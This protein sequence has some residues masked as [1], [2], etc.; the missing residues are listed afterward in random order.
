M[1]GNLTRI[2][3]NQI[4]DAVGGNTQLGIDASTK[5]QN[6][7]ITS[8]KL[9]NDITYGSNL[10]ITGN[11]AVQ[12]NTTTID[13]T[14][15]T[16]EDPILLLAS[17][18]TGTPAVDIGY[19]GQ[20]GTFDN[21]AFVWDEAN[22]AFVTIYTDST[23]GVDTVNT[24]GYANI[25]TGN[26]NIT[27]N[28]T[29]ANI[30]FSGNVTGDLNVTGN[31]TGNNISAVNG[32]TASTANVTNV[33]NVGSVETVT[34]TATGNVT[35]GNVNTGGNVSATGNVTGGNINTAGNISGA[36]VL[37][38]TLANTQVVFAGTSGE[39]L[40]SNDFVYTSAG[41]NVTGN[42]SAGGNVLGNLLY[43]KEANVASTGTV[44]ISGLPTGDGNPVNGSANLTFTTGNLL[45]VTGD[46]S[47]TGNITAG[48]INAN[49]TANVTPG[50]IV[51]AGNGGAL[52][53]N[54]NLT[55]DEANNITTLGNLSA[56][57]NV[58]TNGFSSVTGNVTAGNIL[59][60]T[61]IV[62][63]VGTITG[64]DILSSN[65]A[66]GTG[67]ISATGN[68]TGENFLTAG[69]VSATGNVDGGNVNTGGIVSAIGNVIGGNVST[70]GNVVGSGNVVAGNLITNVIDATG[71]MTI[72][73]VN[74]ISINPDGGANGN[75]NV[76]SAHINNVQTPV[77]DGDA[78]NKGYVDAV[79][80]GLDLKS[81][82][83][84]ATTAP[85]DT[86]AEVTNV[87]YFNGAANDGVGATLTVTTTSALLFDGVDLQH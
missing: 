5:L 75:I 41:L 72:T 58:V 71:T 12:G 67:T 13:T 80:E 30:S 57:G 77:Q 66:G 36:N 45:T 2:N 81:S 39:L 76:N 84:V 55:F 49:I 83:D 33:A 1:A 47:V 79:A 34:V 18:Q 60:P 86:E 51:F 17:N 73:A 14:T 10:T 82:V 23:A 48:N 11:L 19:V 78:A 26:A 7:S 22:V 21:I 25:I 50:Q 15:V 16:I 27:G 29:A 65:V 61:G 3:N 62:S 43:T 68:I 40:G 37:V 4:T 59:V 87:V 24:L 28:L 53:G 35:G 64:T 69:L 8:G 85:L 31:I 70:L 63:A 44:L 52:I 56:T 6:Y 46:A 20:R 74:G 38:T 32:L 42:V 54:V 9:A